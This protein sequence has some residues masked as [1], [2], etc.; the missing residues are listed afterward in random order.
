M[1]TD[2]VEVG[3]CCFC[4]EPIV[5]RFAGQYGSREVWVRVHAAPSATDHPART[6]DEVWVGDDPTGS[7]EYNVDEARWVPAR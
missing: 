4:G 7:M 3:D 1:S 2:D 5:N 6:T